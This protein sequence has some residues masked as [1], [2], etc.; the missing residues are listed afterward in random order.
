[1]TEDRMHEP[2]RVT[3]GVPV[4]NGGRLLEEMLESL[5]R[6]SYRQFR[7]VICDNAST[8]DTPAIA[9]R[10]AASDPRFSYHRNPTNIGAAPNFNRAFELDHATPYF[11]WAAHDDLYEPTYLESCI[12]A[13]D[14]DPDA[15]VAY[16]MTV[17]VD[18]T[19]EGLALDTL[20]LDDA[21]VDSYTDDRNRPCWTIGPLHLAEGKDPV[22]RLE[23]LLEQMIGSFEIFG[24]MRTSALER[25]ELHASYYGSDRPLLAQLVLMGPFRQVP[26]RLYINRYHVAASRRLSRQQLRT[27]I[28][29]KGSSRWRVLHLYWDL[30]RAPFIARLSTR[31][32]LRCGFVIL[33]NFGTRYAGRL[34]RKLA[35]TRQGRAEISTSPIKRGTS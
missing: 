21:V 24:V 35:R 26:E 16:P 19:R 33:R 25:T 7:V 30:L 2:A 22:H 29:T 6:Q 17:L 20:C 13:L 31:D 14:A 8:D 11:K 4:Y 10:F 12:A 15:V 32:R 3:I 9:G 5:R 1:M 23:Q 18:E 34:N 27:W 28:D